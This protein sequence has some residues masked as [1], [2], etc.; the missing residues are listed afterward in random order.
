M[1]VIET[2]ASPTLRVNHTTRP[3]QLAFS[4][5]MNAGR[6]LYTTS[7]AFSKRMKEESFSAFSVSCSWVR[8]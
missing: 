6:K 7:A 3:H 2:G 4:K 5:R 8:V 1:P